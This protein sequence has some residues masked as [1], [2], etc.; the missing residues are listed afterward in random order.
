MG[1]SGIVVPMA[2]LVFFS[3]LCF[4]PNGAK[5]EDTK[6]I[7]VFAAASTLSALTRVVRVYSKSNAIK[8]VPIFAS[9]G[10]LARHIDAGMPGHIFLSA[11]RHWMNWLIKRGRINTPSRRVFLENRLVIAVPRKSTL[12]LSLVGGDL[13]GALGMGRLAMADPDHVPLGAYGRAALKKLG[14]WN[15][16]KDRALRL[17]DA[18]R[19]RVIVERGEAIAGILY[20]SD[21]KGNPKLRAAVRFDARNHPPI[22]YEIA[23]L[24][25]AVNNAAALS[26]LEWLKGAVAKQIFTNAG[27]QVK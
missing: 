15:G 13:A 4:F 1:H 17:S 26:F 27:F 11:N 21:I 8:I 6:S 5:A 9:S 14:V 23:L 10:A 16:V 24:Q 19:T 7:R 12:K 20:A 2:T 25:R 22:H 18:A 3:V